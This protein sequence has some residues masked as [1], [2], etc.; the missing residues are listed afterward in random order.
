MIDIEKNSKTETNN[1]GL[2]I[3]INEELLQSFLNYLNKKDSFLTTNSYYNILYSDSLSASSIRKAW[4]EYLYS[5]LKYPKEDQA[6]NTEILI[7][8]SL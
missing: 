1:D 7:N 5:E 6:D 2:L 4:D 8:K 3:D